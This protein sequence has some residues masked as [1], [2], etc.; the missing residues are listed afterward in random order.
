LKKI[1]RENDFEIELSLPAACSGN[2]QGDRIG[3]I[4]DY[5][6]ICYYGQH[7]EHY[8]SSPIFEQLFDQKIGYV[9]YLTKKGLGYILGDFFTNSSDHPCNSGN[10]IFFQIFPNWIII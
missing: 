2:C 8:R 1:W 7:F 6:A 9:L 4:F 10:R 5:W 3:R